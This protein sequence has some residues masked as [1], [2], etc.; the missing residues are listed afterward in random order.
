MVTIETHMLAD[1][2]EGKALRIGCAKQEL[3]GLMNSCKRSY[4]N[5]GTIQIYL[6]GEIKQHGHGQAKY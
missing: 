2:L 4:C 1:D 6:V 3:H 5:V